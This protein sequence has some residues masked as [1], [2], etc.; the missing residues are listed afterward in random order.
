MKK[1][2]IIVLLVILLVVISFG[3]Y[4]YIMLNKYYVEEYK[5]DNSKIFNE[6]MTITSNDDYDGERINIEDMSFANYFEGYVDK[7]QHT[8]VKYNDEGAIDSFY[9]TN[10]ST[11]YVNEF[12]VN[13]FSV[14]D[15]DEDKDTATDESTKKFFSENNIKNDV[16]LLYY[17]KNNYY[18]KNNT[19]TS[20]NTMKNNYLVN[21]F[22]VT[23]TVSYNNITLINGSL[24]GYIVDVKNN[25][26]SK[27]K[28]LHIIKGDK[29][30]TITLSGSEITSDS[31][32]KDLLSTV[33]FN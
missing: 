7:L 32:I 11:Q 24:D 1:K 23:T 27:I 19:L 9:M 2:G 4:K 17:V 33:K 3:V 20:T 12:S 22:V 13:S 6:T 8:K 26:D 30:Y 28:E 10:V 25:I 29:H 5:I 16:D 31:F 18:L 14:S 15:S 21:S